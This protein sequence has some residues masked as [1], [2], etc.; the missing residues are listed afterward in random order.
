[1]HHLFA[2]LQLWKLFANYVLLFLLI[3]TVVFLASL[4]FLVLIPGAV[5]M[6]I[7]HTIFLTLS[8]ALWVGWLLM[9]YNYLKSKLQRKHL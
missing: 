9:T 1:M 6:E 8:V 5:G 2:P 4:P 3:S 7:A